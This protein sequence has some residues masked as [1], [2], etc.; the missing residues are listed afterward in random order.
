VS[1]DT[2]GALKLDGQN[3]Y[4]PGPDITYSELTSFDH[5][6]IYASVE[7][8]IPASYQGEFPMLVAAFHHNGEAYKYR[9]ETVSPD[10]LK[11]GDWNT[12]SFYYLTPEVRTPH[13]NLKVYLWQREPS[14]I[15][16]RNFNVEVWETKK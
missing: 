16:I 5:A 6:W 3:P 8:F 4:A 2:T 7:V 11:P 9:T 10:S 1:A 12:I 14:T 13:D 15:Y